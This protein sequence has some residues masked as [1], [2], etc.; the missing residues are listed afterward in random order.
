MDQEAVEQLERERAR[1]VSQQ[2]RLVNRNEEVIAA[3]TGRALND[4]EIRSIT[5]RSGEVEAIQA[6]VDRIDSE[7]SQPQPRQTSPHAGDPIGGLNGGRISVPKLS[8]GRRFQDLFGNRSVDPYEGRFASLG[9]F[10]IAVAGGGSDPRLMHIRNSSM[11]ES[12]GVGGGFLVP[13]A[14]LA[15]VLDGAL[16]D[17]AVRPRATVVPF[18]GGAA[19]VAGFDYQDGTSGASANLTLRWGMEGGSLAEQT[20]KAR[21]LTVRPHK[22]SIY[23]RVSNECVTD[24]PRFDLQLRRAMRGAVATGLDYAFVQGSGVGQPLGIIPAPGTITVGKESGQATGTLLLQNLAKMIA[25]L[26]PGSFN[27]S[28]WMVH[29]TVL[30]LLYQM[31]VVVKNVAGT[32]NVGGGSAAVTVDAEGNVRIYGR[33]VIVSDACS[34]LSSLGDIIL[35]DWTGYLIGMRMDATIA[36]DASKHFDTDEVAFRLILRLDGL[37]INSTPVKLR[38]GTDTVSH[39]V[40]LEAR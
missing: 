11:G 39:F 18:E 20:A 19:N 17:E 7:L 29:Q 12:T 13:T 16:E 25:R 30:P 8:G 1:L 23:V 35:A 14:F 24:A 32:E 33:P 34:A 10:G 37:P 40:M 6:A 28:A 3:A 22:G 31:T 27:R 21:E 38:N 26:R 5:R 9:D 2:E 4:G 15:G 36:A